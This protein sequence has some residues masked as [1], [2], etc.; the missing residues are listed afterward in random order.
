MKLFTC[1]GLAALALGA[2]V[3]APSDA[4]SRL[5]ALRIGD[6]G[7]PAPNWHCTFMTNCDSCQ[8]Y[9]APGIHFYYKCEKN[10]TIKMCNSSVEVNNCIQGEITQAWDCG[11]V[12]QYTG[13]CTGAP[14]TPPIQ[15]LDNPCAY[16]GC[17]V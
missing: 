6:E 7:D 9:S 15:T 5:A 1:V 11:T 16:Q 13:F 10:F 14:I 17:K 12:T 3:A 4:A 2:L 8:G